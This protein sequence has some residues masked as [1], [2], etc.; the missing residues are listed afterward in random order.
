MNFEHTGNSALTTEF[1]ALEKAV[2]QLST[3]WCFTQAGNMCMKALQVYKFTFNNDFMFKISCFNLSCWRL[4]PCHLSDRYV[5]M[6]MYCPS[7]T[8]LGYTSQSRKFEKFINI[9]LNKKNLEEEFNN[10]F[11][12]AATRDFLWKLFLNIWQYSP[13]EDTCDGVSF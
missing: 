11:S 4:F 12:E 7:V 1:L 13:H 3:I 6:K 8:I 5:D 9:H 2:N 10:S